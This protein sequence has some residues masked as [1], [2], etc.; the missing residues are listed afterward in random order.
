MKANNPLFVF[1]IVTFTGL[2]TSTAIAQNAVGSGILDVNNIKTTINANGQLFGSLQNIPE[3]EK[4][5]FEIKNTENKHAIR[6]AG[7]WMG[8]KAAN[9]YHIYAPT[10]GEWGRD[11]FPGPVM[12]KEFYNEVEDDKWNRV[13]KISKE[14]IKNHI[15][16]FA[17]KG[18]TLSEEISNWPASGDIDKGQSPNLA[19][20]VDV[21]ANG[22]YDP[23]NGDYPSIKGDEAILF[24]FNDHRGQH[25]ESG[26]NKMGV[27]VIGLAYAY[28]LPFNKTYNNTIFVDYTVINHSGEDYSET[29]LGVFTDIDLGA[30]IFDEYQG[31]DIKRNMYYGY[32]AENKNPEMFGNSKT[33]YLSVTLLN[34]PFTGYMTYNNDL[35]VN[36][37]PMSPLDYYL[38]LNGYWK[39]GYMISK[40]GFGKGGKDRTSFMYDGNPISG[41]GWNEKSV[42]NVP[43]DRRGLGIIGPF[44]FKKGHVKKISVAYNFANDFEKL[45]NNADKFTYDYKNNSGP[46]APEAPAFANNLGLNEMKPMD[47][48]VYPNPANALTTIFFDNPDSEK[49]ALNVYDIN[50]RKVLS[51]NQLKGT[52]YQINTAKFEKGLYVIELVF[53]DRRNSLR[54]VVQ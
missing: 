18:Y 14:I 23:M 8:G 42:N 10:F 47:M 13:W 52:Q 19:P 32:N 26:T 30:N 4:R 43:G 34:E 50:G 40:G 44:E 16:N 35:N 38:Y 51:E 54:L 20:F 31:I 12:K 27:E 22:I 2:L 37:N 17:S 46:F 39:D 48:M 3:S 7:I 1:Y 49:Y 24:I 21:N 6:I 36:G 41:S 45:Q 33:P 11:V 53:K 25:T 29:K 28:A 9:N 5:S 15:T